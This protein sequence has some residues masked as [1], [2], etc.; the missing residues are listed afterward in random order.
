[1]LPFPGLEGWARAASM[2]PMASLPAPLEMTRP[3]TTI[4]APTHQGQWVGAAI[5]VIGLVVSSGAGTEVIGRMLAARAQ[6]AGPGK[7]DIL[8]R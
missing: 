8:D 6:P 1:M 5:V 7:G 2:R 3:V 4:A